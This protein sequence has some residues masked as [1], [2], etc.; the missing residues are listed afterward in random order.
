MSFK[1]PVFMCNLKTLISCKYLI[2]KIITSKS[3]KMYHK[4]YSG[5][6]RIK[7][8]VKLYSNYNEEYWFL[9]GTMLVMQQIKYKFGYSLFNT[10]N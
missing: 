1:K 3:V 9:Y 4:M 7:K 5:N 8:I 6:T 2:N 10:Q